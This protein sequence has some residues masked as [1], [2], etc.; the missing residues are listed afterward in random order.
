MSAESSNAA[1]LELDAQ[2]AAAQPASVRTRFLL[3]WTAA[4]IATAAALIAH[5]APRLETVRLGYDVGQARREQRELL[6]S[7]RMLA[8]ESATLRE[9]GRV[10]TVARGRLGMDVPEPERVV[11]VGSGARRGTAGRMR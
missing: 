4:V 9:P 7:Q 5:L 11:P 6:E 8:I 2:S 1:D 10:E 3:L